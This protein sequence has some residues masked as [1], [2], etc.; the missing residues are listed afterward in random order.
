MK[1]IIIT[2]LIILSITTV[3]AKNVNE[4]FINKALAS[5]N[6]DQLVVAGYI[7]KSFE[8]PYTNQ[9]LYS[10]ALKL[11]PNNILLLEQMVRFCNDNSSICQKQNRYLKRLEKLDTKN[12]VPN[13]YAI[14]YYGENK[15][16]SK[17]LKQLKK[18]VK[19]K[20]YED[21]NWKRFFL[22]DKVLN[23]YGYKNNQAKKAAIKSLFI[24]FDSEPMVKIINLCVNQSKINSQWIEPCIHLGKIM[25]TSSTMVLSTFLGYRIQRNVL[26]LDKNREVEYENVKQRRDVFHQYR[27]RVVNNIKYASMGE[28]VNFDDIPDVFFQYLEKF[29][30]RVALQRALD[31][32]EENK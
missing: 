5:D 7:A 29:G 19:K 10:K 12:S 32:L 9:Q 22:V 1:K 4:L 28:D 30:E 17:A 13:L 24:E 21:Y 31:R 2:L 15:Q 20:V 16:Y 8:L 6:I 25:E 11:A 23:S 14:E 3:N 26:A 27:L 18:A